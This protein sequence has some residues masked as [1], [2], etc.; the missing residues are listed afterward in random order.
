MSN[1]PTNSAIR[2]RLNLPALEGTSYDPPFRN[3]FFPGETLRVTCE[4][5]YWIVKTQYTTTETT[6]KEDGEWSIR[7]ICQGNKTARGLCKRQI[8]RLLFCT[9]CVWLLTHDD[10]S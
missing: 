2:C 3:A 10:G 1:S 5:K 6:C 4:E 8:V 7:P 9:A